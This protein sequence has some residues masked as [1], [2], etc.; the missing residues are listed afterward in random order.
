MC[1][2][3]AQGSVTYIFYMYIYIYI[4][5]W[6]KSKATC[7]PCLLQACFMHEAIIRCN[8]RMTKHVKSSSNCRVQYQKRN[9]VLS[10]SLFCL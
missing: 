7:F 2:L 9:Q 6:I 4:Y 5:I 1:A 10:R 8:K 3:W